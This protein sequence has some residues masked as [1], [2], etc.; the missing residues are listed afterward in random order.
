MLKR[1]RFEKLTQ[2]QLQQ[3]VIHLES[4]LVQCRSI[5]ETKDR[6]Y[7]EQIIR[8][9]QDNDNLRREMQ[10]FINEQKTYFQERD[11]LIHEYN[12]ML[13]KTMVYQTKLAQLMESNGVPELV[14]KTDQVAGGEFRKIEHLLQEAIKEREEIFEDNQALQESLKE[15]HQKITEK[16]ERIESLQQGIVRLQEGTEEY[17]N[18]VE[19]LQKR[20]KT[21]VQRNKEMGAELSEVQKI[22]NQLNKEKGTLQ[23][24][25]Q[26]K[27]RVL[28]NVTAQNRDFVQQLEV[29]NENVEQITK[30]N[31]TYL[32]KITQLDSEKHAALKLFENNQTELSN[33]KTQIM[34]LKTLKNKLLNR[35]KN[36]M[37]EVRRLEKENNQFLEEKDG[38]LK[39]ITILDE[40]NTLFRDS[41]IEF[42]IKRD[43]DEKRLDNIT[44]SLNE[45]FSQT[46]TIIRT[47]SLLQDQLEEKNRE[48]NQVKKENEKLM[49]EII[50]LN[51]DF[52]KSEARKSELENQLEIMKT[53]LLKA[54]D[55]LTRLELFETEKLKLKDELETK[56][57]EFNN[58]THNYQREKE[59]YLHVLEHVQDQVNQYKE[60]SDFFDTEKGSWSKQ[61]DELKSELAETKATLVKM[62][63]LE[64]E[65][66]VL[67]AELEAKE[68]EIYK[69][70]K[71]N[72][73]ALHNQMIQF[74]SEM[75][76]YKEKIDQ[77]EKDRVNTENQMN[78]MKAKFAILESN[79]KEK[80]NF[81]RQFITQPPL[82]SRVEK[83]AEPVMEF[84]KNAE[85]P[86]PS[87]IKPSLPQGQQSGDWFQRNISQQQG[88]YQNVPKTANSS[89]AAMDFFTLRSKTTQPSSP[90]SIY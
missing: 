79:L 74:N 2:I 29:L 30:K 23:N 56:I 8:L 26:L 65:K 85:Q 41:I 83:E 3:K 71:E 18:T 6:S 59:S 10:G 86:L 43:L 78:E 67:T 32:Q 69:I 77:Y 76:L 53:E 88:Q 17:K 49:Q 7:R 81:I 82:P 13:Q 42:S 72:E 60:K 44:C 68:I 38:L 4:E 22:L 33:A 19:L 1:H 14:E 37:K 16:D 39:R 70:Q 40:E 12:K 20:E 15:L 35:L 48:I 11:E 45:V 5:S 84:T 80:E 31:V 90:G 47:A 36:R 75:K 87:E 34:E 27:K 54:Q 21:L 50:Q 89:P 52:E 66:E 58:L 51:N 55:S 46:Q 63:E 28:N 9:R 64:K 57:E 24:E 61:I 25:L 62:E 73:R